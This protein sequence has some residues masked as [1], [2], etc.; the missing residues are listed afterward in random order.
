M[1]KTTPTASAQ[2]AGFCAE[3]GAAVG[4]FWRQKPMRPT[5]EIR[6]PDRGKKSGSLN[7]PRWF[8]GGILCLENGR[9][10]RARRGVLLLEVKLG[11]R[12]PGSFK[13]LESRR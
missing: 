4:H 10:R 8:P 5:A 2:R 1:P 7:F 13:R 6:A 12:N 3:S 9:Y 11:G